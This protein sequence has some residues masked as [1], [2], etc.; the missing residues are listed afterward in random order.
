[1]MLQWNI[2]IIHIEMQ[3]QLDILTVSKAEE[4]FNM[5]W[6]EEL[7]IQT[8]QDDTHAEL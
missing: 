7:I 3:K 8:Q 1:M 5:T 4:L 6:L 2:E